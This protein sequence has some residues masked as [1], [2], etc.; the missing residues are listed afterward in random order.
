VIPALALAFA[1]SAASIVAIYA[2]FAHLR[3]A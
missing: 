2:G 1:A 3:R